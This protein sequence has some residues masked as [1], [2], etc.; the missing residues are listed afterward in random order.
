MPGSRRE[1]DASGERPGHPVVGRPVLPAGEAARQLVTSTTQIRVMIE[2]D[3]L[4][5][6]W[7]RRGKYDY[8]FVYED[9]LRDWLTA[10]GTYG[11]TR[12]AKP[13]T[14]RKSRSGGASAVVEQQLSELLA[15]QDAIATKL[16]EQNEALSQAHAQVAEQAARLLSLEEAVRRLTAANGRLRAAVKHEED[17]ASHL[18]AA[19]ESR[20]LA[21]QEVATAEGEVEEVAAGLGVPDFVRPSVDL[22]LDTP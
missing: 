19:D 4:E 1:I 22:S 6:Y 11:A 7:R 8:F 14:P 17:A 3:R 5:G 21:L 2:D 12:Q 13:H 16:D 18:R 10:H 15:N 20:S 9:S